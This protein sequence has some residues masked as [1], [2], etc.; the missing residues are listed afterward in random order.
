MLEKN[1]RII[2][3][4]EE[5]WSRNCILYYRVS[6]LITKKTNNLPL[7]CTSTKSFTIQLSFSPKKIGTE[8]YIHEITMLTMR[9]LYCIF[10]LCCYCCRYFTSVS[11]DAQQP[12][13]FEYV[14]ATNHND[15]RIER[16]VTGIRSISIVNNSRVLK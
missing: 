11:H 9:D 3:S 14:I 2:F 12:L 6:E 15:H 13:Y 4:K 7:F 16:E 10:I 1:F 5:V 8:V